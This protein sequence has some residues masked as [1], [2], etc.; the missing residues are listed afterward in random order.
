MRNAEGGPAGP[1]RCPVPCRGDLH[2]VSIV[3][4]AKGWLEQSLRPTAGIERLEAHVDGRGPKAPGQGRAVGHY[5]A[6]GPPKGLQGAAWTGA[7][8][9]GPVDRCGHQRVDVGAVV[10]VRPEQC[11]L[12]KQVSRGQPTHIPAPGN[13]QSQVAEWPLHDIGM[14]WHNPAIEA[15]HLGSTEGQIPRAG[16]ARCP[17][18]GQRPL[19]PM[20]IARWGLGGERFSVCLRKADHGRCPSRPNVPKQPRCLQLVDRG[21]NCGSRAQPQHH[22]LTQARLRM[23]RAEW[24]NARTQSLRRHRHRRLYLLDL[25]EHRSRRQADNPAPREARGRP[26][27]GLDLGKDFPFNR[28]LR[29]GG[30]RCKTRRAV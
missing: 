29:G 17:D 27:L 1:R 25:P 6:A 11:R 12:V 18:R 21:F 28:R 13:M 5:V 14:A 9:A 30:A 22:C 8:H 4:H 20:R 7:C 23:L 10:H 16:A 24:G 19:P 26:E 2:N 3:H 15:G